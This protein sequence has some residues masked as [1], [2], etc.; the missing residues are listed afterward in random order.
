MEGIS[1]TSI[2][3]N[4]LANRPVELE[5]DQALTDLVSRTRGVLGCRGV[6]TGEAMQRGVMQYH[7]MTTV[8]EIIVMRDFILPRNI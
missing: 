4:E 7:K 2:L 8:N 5:R 1:Y 3:G 6:T